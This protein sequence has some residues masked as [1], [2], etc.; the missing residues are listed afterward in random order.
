MLK[1][2]L[3]KIGK[4]KCCTCK[5]IKTIES[6]P[7]DKHNPD[8]YNYQCKKC[9]SKWKKANINYFRN[10]SIKNRLKIKIGQQSA[11]LK[12]KY[13]L[14]LEAFNRMLQEQNGV[15]A[16][17]GKPETR[18]CRGSLCSLSVDHNHETG[19]IRELLCSNCNVMLAKCD[20][21]I[22]WLDKIKNY[23]VKH[24]Q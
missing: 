3:Y 13:N 21:S 7:K 17:C 23:I 10:Y 11:T 18:I 19:K 8:G 1:E 22:E 16:I 12:L 15:C 6:F 9:R 24:N 2:T 4:K 5:K 14:S 20:E